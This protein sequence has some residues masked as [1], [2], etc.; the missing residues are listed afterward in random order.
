MRPNGV[1]EEAYSCIYDPT[2]ETEYRT[3]STGQV[4][5]R[6]RVIAVPKSGNSSTASETQ[7]GQSKNDARTGS[8]ARV[9]P[10]RFCSEPVMGRKHVTESEGG[11]PSH[12]ENVLTWFEEEPVTNYN[13][14][15]LASKGVRI[16]NM[17]TL[18][19]FFVLVVL[20]L[21]ILALASFMVI[22]IVT[23]GRNET[24]LT[25]WTG[26]IGTVFGVW[27]PQPKIP[28]VDMNQSHSTPTMLHPAAPLP[29]PPDLE[30]G[31]K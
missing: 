6:K 26:L 1:P 14:P 19:R 23:S 3:T 5:R 2:G 30:L 25:V 29:E 4:L 16:N 20:S 21:A 15:L 8:P 11:S 9:S 31:V 7:Q 28:K 22:Y 13:A 10:P 12:S 17:Q 18:G 27:I 24:S